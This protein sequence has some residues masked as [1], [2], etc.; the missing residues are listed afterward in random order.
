MRAKRAIFNSLTCTAIA[1]LILCSGSF[2]LCERPEPH[3][4]LRADKEL[5]EEVVPVLNPHQDSSNLNKKI[6]NVKLIGEFNER[7]RQDFGYTGIVPSRLAQNQYTQVSYLPG[8]QISLAEDGLRRDRYGQ[9]IVRRLA[10]FHMDRYAKNSKSLK[11]AY[12]FKE[13]VS[14]YNIKIKKGYGLKINYSLVTNSMKVDLLNPFKIKASYSVQMDS[15][16]VGPGEATEQVIS[17][18]YPVDKRT[19]VETHYK[20]V[21]NKLS[22]VGRRQLESNLEATLSWTSSAPENF[23]ENT[24]GEIGE[25]L[26]LM[27]FLWTL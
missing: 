21:S 8:E 7:Y 10:E 17:L 24:T 23:I 14:K 9:F 22:L 19:Q 11:K 6:F 2:G 13:V 1:A 27:G 25:E 18:S 3:Q 4:N 20:G 16:S 5:V 26:L 15:S 12:E